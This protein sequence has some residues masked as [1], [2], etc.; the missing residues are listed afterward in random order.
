[1]TIRTRLAVQFV[2][3][4]SLTLGVAFAVVYLRAAE[5]RQEE[6]LGR[7]H[8][9]GVNAA[10]LLIQVEQ[11]DDKL[12]RIMEGK[13]PVRLPEEEITIFDQDNVEMLHLGGNTG[14]MVIEPALV[15]S[16]RAN[17]RVIR[18]IA[19]RE[20]LAFEFD[21]EAGRYVVVTSGRDIYGRRKLR[22]QARVMVATFLT[23]LLLM[24][25]VGRVYARRALSPLQR[26]VV[27]LH[28]IGASDLGQ[29]IMMGEGSDEIAQLASSFND[30]LERLQT[31]FSVQKNF[32]SNASH[33]MRTPLTAISGQLEVL[34]LKERSG[35]EY[36]A[37][38]RSV[39]EDMQALNRLSDRLLLMAQA[40]T[41]SAAMTF[42]PVRMDEVVWAARSEVLRAD[43]DNRVDVVIDEVEEAD[44]IT[45]KGNEAL[46]RSVV[47]NL[48]ENA[49]KYSSDKRALV[50]LKGSG[51]MVRL[52][53]EDQG[54]GIA[55]EDR[56]RIFE[57]FYRARNT[58]GAKGHGIGLSLVKRIVDLHGGEINVQ[59]TLGS[60]TVFI[61]R[62]H[63]AE[64]IR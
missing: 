63:K 42:V 9:R 61:V 43:P 32:I 38:L 26:L 59:S 44:D 62:L 4:A 5:F 25:L 15:D 6:F 28:G 21:D 46:L 22:N 8:D 60:G 56:E 27:D 49:C 30:L 13:S 50:S 64:T 47:V 36:R 39:V 24:F 19:D 7:L 10:K 57:N 34:L 40:E 33:E 55:P 35:E 23:G 41:A 11:V 12:L 53:I 51:T 20:M 48:L 18:V 3:L 16:V 37:A 45:V 58:G 1:M 29:R 52:A 2:V 31:A 17:G 54:V 14:R